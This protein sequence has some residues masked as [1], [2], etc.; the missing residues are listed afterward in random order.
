MGSIENGPCTSCTSLRVDLGLGPQATYTVNSRKTRCLQFY[1]QVTY[2]RQKNDYVESIGL[3]E[4]IW[5][6]KC[7]RVILNKSYTVS[8][9]QELTYITT[10]DVHGKHYIKTIHEYKTSSR[11]AYLLLVIR[12]CA[13]VNMKSRVRFNAR[14]GSLKVYHVTITKTRGTWAVML[15]W[16]CSKTVL[17][18]NLSFSNLDC[19]YL[20]FGL[21]CR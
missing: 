20:K 18:F 5:R 13:I 16:Q 3:H 14:R 9:V 21:G 11:L 1:T 7:V 8:Q 2:T 19:C 4:I 17:F 12:V 15:T 6:N 10:H